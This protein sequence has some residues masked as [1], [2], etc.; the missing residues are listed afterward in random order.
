MHQP[1]EALGARFETPLVSLLLSWIAPHQ[2]VLPQKVRQGT[3]LLSGNVT[4]QTLAGLLRG[5]RFPAAAYERQQ[6]DGRFSQPVEALCYRVMQQPATLS[7][8]ILLDGMKLEV[9][10]QYRQGGV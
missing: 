7:I 10:T 8:P 5:D 1:L 3:Q 9:L 4:P 6:F 2:I